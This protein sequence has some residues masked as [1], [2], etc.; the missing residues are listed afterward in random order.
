M[1]CGLQNF[2]ALNHNVV[3]NGFIR[4]CNWYRFLKINIDLNS[5][6]GAHVNYFVNKIR[7][8][9]C[10][11]SSNNSMHRTL[12]RL[13]VQNIAAQ[14]NSDQPSVKVPVMLIR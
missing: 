8:K 9:Y 14:Y 11:S 3:G 12:L 5:F 6:L 4:L 1:F 10:A 13:V 2:A 7:P